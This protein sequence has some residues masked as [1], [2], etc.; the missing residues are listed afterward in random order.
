MRARAR[1]RERDC[2]DQLAENFPRTEE[3]N[4]MEHLEAEFIKDNCPGCPLVSHLGTN[5]ILKIAE[6]Y[7]PAVDAMQTSGPG[8]VVIERRQSALGQ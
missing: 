5:S 6:N 8:S 2:F 7:K 3:D 1:E 4:P